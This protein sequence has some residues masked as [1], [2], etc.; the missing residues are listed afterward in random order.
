M[1]ARDPRNSEGVLPQNETVLDARPFRA[2]LQTLESPR[3][4]KGM[5]TMPA[6]AVE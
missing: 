4:V 2:G 6:K 3:C 1:D 5:L